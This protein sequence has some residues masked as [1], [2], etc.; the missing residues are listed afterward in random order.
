MGR[1]PTPNSVSRTGADYLRLVFEEVGMRS[2]RELV[3]GIL[4]RHYVP[5]VS[6][7]TISSRRRN[8]RLP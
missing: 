4:L 1:E 6:A 2:R 7:P 5:R 3:A 8:P